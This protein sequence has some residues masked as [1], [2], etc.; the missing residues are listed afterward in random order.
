MI[1]YT[2]IKSGVMEE[3]AAHLLEGTHFRQSRVAL[4]KLGVVRCISA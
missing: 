1:R 3:G 4:R 2:L